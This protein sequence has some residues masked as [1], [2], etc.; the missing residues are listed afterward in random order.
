MSEDDQD[1][2]VGA[3]PAHSGPVGADP[4]S[5]EQVAADA[6]LAGLPPDDPEDWTD[7]QW[8]DWLQATDDSDGTDQSDQSGSPQTAVHRIARAAGGSVLG[9]AMLGMAYAIYGRNES[10]V[11]IVAEDDSEPDP[12]APFKIEIDNEDPSKSSVEIRENRRSRPHD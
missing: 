4:V 11:S 9:N 8:I 7:Q 3:D 5:E 1:R 2:P 6:G 10:E 12:D